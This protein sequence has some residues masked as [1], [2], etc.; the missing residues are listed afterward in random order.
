MRGKMSPAQP[1][2]Q[3]RL[4][5]LITPRSV[6]IMTTARNI[7]H[8]G[9]KDS[10]TNGYVCPR[11][12]KS[13]KSKCGFAKDENEV[14]DYCFFGVGDALDLNKILSWKV[15]LSLCYDCADG[16]SGSVHPNL[17]APC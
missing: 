5:M 1:S 10:A 15:K 11:Y 9:V 14:A 7:V 2:P 17:R 13:S 8:T 16:E 3:G 12:R 6:R 4:L